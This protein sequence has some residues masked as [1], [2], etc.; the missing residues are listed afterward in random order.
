[1]KNDHSAGI[2]V[3]ALAVLTLD[4]IEITTS[5]ARR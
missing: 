3:D 5:A 2:A 4:A 1:M